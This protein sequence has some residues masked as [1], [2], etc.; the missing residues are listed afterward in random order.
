M[1]ANKAPEI[2]TLKSLQGSKNLAPEDLVIIIKALSDVL[3]LQILFVLKSDSFSVTELCAIFQLAQPKLSHHLKV[4]ASAGL[5]ATRREGNSI[6]YRRRLLDIT[7]AKDSFVRAF[8]THVDNMQ[9]TTSIVDHIDKIKS[10][11]AQTSLNFFS[12]NVNNFGE[13]QAL[14]CEYDQFA[15]NLIDLLNMSHLHSSAKA[16]EVG[17]G[18]GGFL[19]EL[20]SR[21]SHVT[22]IDNSSPMLRLAEQSASSVGATNIDFLLRSR[23]FK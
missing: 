18:E 23:I 10:H 7:C 22:A 17:A 5:V 8:L 19:V 21:F 15:S 11:R 20:A 12:K 3:R 13:N 16:I 9:I 2:L 4:M 1:I 6:F 14:I